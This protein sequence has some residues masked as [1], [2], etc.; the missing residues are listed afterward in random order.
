MK[1]FFDKFKRKKND[2][3][4]SMEDFQKLKK[5][6]DDKKTEEEKKGTLENRLMNVLKNQVDTLNELKTVYNFLKKQ[7]EPAEKVLTQHTK[8]KIAG[9]FIDREEEK[10]FNN[11]PS[12]AKENIEDIDWDGQLKNLK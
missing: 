2:N 8:S 5:T 6:L 7:N 4:F 1:Q 9:E 10:K 12:L 3:G 11:M